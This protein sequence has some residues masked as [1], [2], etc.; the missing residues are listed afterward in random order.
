MLSVPLNKGVKPP[1]KPTLPIGW[2]WF[3]VLAVQAYN[4]SSLLTHQLHYVA[5]RTSFSDTSTSYSTQA[6]RVYWN[7]KTLSLQSSS[8]SKRQCW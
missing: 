2:H 3:T 8:P 1:A 7:W 4:I 6:N 5:S